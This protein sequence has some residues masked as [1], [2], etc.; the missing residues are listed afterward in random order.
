MAIPGIGAVPGLGS[1]AGAPA[2]DTLSKT[3]KAGDSGFGNAITGALDNL[4]ATQNKADSLA[5][6]AAT[7]D[8]Q[9]VHDYMI[10]ATQASLQ[11]ELTVAVRNK[12]LEAFGEI[13]RMQI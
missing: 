7:G 5:L 2:L 13:M 3:S 4:Q 10:A 8:L 12:A 6:D 11:T 9:N 1:I